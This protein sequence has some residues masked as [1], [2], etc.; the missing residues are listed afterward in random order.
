MAESLPDQKDVLRA[1]IKPGGK[2]VPEGMGRPPR[3]SGPLHVK[4]DQVM[5][6][7]PGQGRSLLGDEKVVHVGLF[8]PDLKVVQD[9]LPGCRVQKDP[10]GLAPFAGSDEENPLPWPDFQIPQP[11]I[12]HFA[13]PQ[14]RLGHKV[15]DRPVT[16][17]PLPVPVYNPQEPQ[18]FGMGENLGGLRGLHPHRFEGRRV[19]LSYQ[20]L[21]Q[22]EGEERPDRG[23][24]PVYRL[25]AGFGLELADM[26][27]EVY[28]TEPGKELPRPVTPVGSTVPLGQEAEVGGVGSNGI[29][30]LPP[31]FELLGELPD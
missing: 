7:P 21:L 4:H 9:R 20:P 29:P 23:D 26:I 2:Q 25:G 12:G 18:E 17:A 11:D 19:V 28:G 8:R 31:G 1:V 22:E 5:D 14:A 27:Q 13:D 15:D 10:P 3:E 24:L 6:R 16:P 30:A